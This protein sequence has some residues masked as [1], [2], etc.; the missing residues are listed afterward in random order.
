MDDRT[1]EYL[2][3]LDATLTEIAGLARRGRD[4]YDRDIAVSR[5]CQYNLIRLTADLERLGSDWLAHHPD[6]P[7]R[8][9]KGMRNR[10]AHD[11]LTIDDDIIWAVVEHHATQLHHALENEIATAKTT[12]HTDEQTP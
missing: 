10:I 9:I 3:Y 5:A 11:Y 7:W 12:L 8:L 4:A 1:A 2:V 6:I